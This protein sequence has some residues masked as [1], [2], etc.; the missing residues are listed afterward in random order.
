MAILFTQRVRSGRRGGVNDD[1]NDDPA[2]LGIRQDST[3]ADS[4]ALVEKKLN[5]APNYGMKQWYY[6]YI[7]T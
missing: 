7:D 2:L 5:I 4:C 1:N 6:G 3:R